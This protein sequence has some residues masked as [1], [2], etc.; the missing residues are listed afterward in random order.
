MRCIFINK[1]DIGYVVPSDGKKLWDNVFQCSAEVVVATEGLAVRYYYFQLTAFMKNVTT[2]ETK[3][4]QLALS[5]N[6]NIYLT[7]IWLLYLLF[8]AS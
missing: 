5:Y 4:R 1:V 6:N 7:A 2:L 8:R 3:R